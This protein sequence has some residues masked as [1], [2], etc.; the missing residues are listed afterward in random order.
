MKNPVA[1]IFSRLISFFKLIEENHQVSVI[2][3]IKKDENGLSTVS[4][5]PIF[6]HKSICM[7]ARQA[8]ENKIVRDQLRKSD[9]DLIKGI[10][11]SEGDVFIA[12]KVYR[13]NQEIYTLAS[14]VT[15]EQ[16]NI[17]SEELKNNKDLLSRLNK[18][19][20][21]LALNIDVNTN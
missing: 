12:S 17:E 5:S 4:I 21:S 7:S 20:F 1:A 2:D 3:G 14:P 8:I 13:G 11:I 19:Y 16:W 6:S 10:L 9:I 18:R 15:N